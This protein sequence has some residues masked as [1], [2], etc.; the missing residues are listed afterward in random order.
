[1]YETSFFKNILNSKIFSYYH[2]H[3]NSL[4]HFSQIYIQCFYPSITLGQ[5]TIFF[6]VLTQEYVYWFLRGWGG[7]REREKH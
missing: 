7:G 5:V 2:S 4:L 3:V 6:E 1:M